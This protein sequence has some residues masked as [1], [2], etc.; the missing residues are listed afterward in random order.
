[1]RVSH[2]V[3]ELLHDD[4]S[5]DSCNLPALEPIPLMDTPPL[6]DEDDDDDLDDSCDL[7]PLEPRP[8]R[9][10]SDSDDL[11]RTKY[12]LHNDANPLLCKEFINPTGISRP[13]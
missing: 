1:M 4:D 8:L 13:K 5:I 7:P 2:P 12:N 11:N 10:E 3:L 9:D 6:L